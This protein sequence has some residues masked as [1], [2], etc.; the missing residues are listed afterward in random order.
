MSRW[1]RW[2][3]FLDAR[4][5]GTSMALVRVLVATC[6]LRTIGSV[7][8]SGVYGAAWADRAHGGWRLHLDSDP[9]WRLLG[10]FDPS[11]R[12]GFAIAAVASATLLAL[13]VGGELLAR[14]IALVCLQSF[15]ALGDLNGHA[16][17][18]YDSLITNA[19][20]LLVLAGPT[21]TLSVECRWATGAWTSARPVMRWPRFLVVVQAVLM[22]GTTGWQKLSDHWVPG[23]DLGALWYI[24]QQ[25]TWQLRDMRWLAPLYPLTQ[26]GTLATWLWEVTAPLWLVAWLAEADRGSGGRLYGVLRRLRARDV[27]LALGL[28]FHSLVALTMQIGPFSWASMALYPAFIHPE[29][30]ARLLG[31]RVD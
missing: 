8:W 9:L 26:L 27:Y 19:L 24:E 2:V 25:P 14:L 13:G 11:T 28:V 4:E 23:G 7:W 30:W 21:R 12:D 29:E 3:G 31:R 18:S 10:G 15:M 17:G 6:V 5:V 20:W 1:A 22:Y 16:A